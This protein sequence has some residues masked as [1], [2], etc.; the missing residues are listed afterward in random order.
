[1]T[2]GGERGAY[3]DLTKRRLLKLREKKKRRKGSDLARAVGGVC[4][5]DPGRGADLKGDGK[6]LESEKGKEKKIVGMKI[7]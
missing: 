3:T 2:K 1:V 6:T 4:N 7:T 5:R